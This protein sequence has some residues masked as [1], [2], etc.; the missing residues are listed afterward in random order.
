MKLTELIPMEI[1]GI[2][3]SGDPQLLPD[4][5]F[6]AAPKVKF[7][8]SYFNIGYNDIVMHIDTYILTT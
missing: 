7:K 4:V 2:K 3:H 1:S 5:L 8:L 6:L